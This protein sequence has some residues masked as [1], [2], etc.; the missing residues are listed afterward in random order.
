MLRQ[1]ASARKEGRMSGTVV[2]LSDRPKD[3]ID[4]QVKRRMPQSAIASRLNTL[5]A[6]LTQ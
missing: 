5:K 4:E 3:E 6:P 1:L 2:L